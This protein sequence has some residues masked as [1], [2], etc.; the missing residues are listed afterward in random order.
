MTKVQSRLA[1][2]KRVNSAVDD[3]VAYFTAQSLDNRA[4]QLNSLSTGLTAATNTISEASSGITSIQSLLNAA[5]N[6]ANQA[7][8]GTSSSPPTV[9]GTL[10]NLNSNSVIATT[11]GSGNRFKA[12]DTVTVNDGTT[13]ATYTAANNDTVSTFLAAIN[14]TTGL[15]VTASLNASGQIQLA[16]SSAVTVTVGG[17]INGAGGGTLS[18]I[19]GLTAGATAP[20]TSTNT[21]LR[22][23]LAA[24]YD[25]IRSQIDAAAQDANYNGVN[26]LT[27]S[28]LSVNLNETGSSKLAISGGNLASAGLGMSASTNNWQSNSDVNNAVTQINAAMATLQT[29]S[30]VIGA[31]SITLQSRQDF[32]KATISNLQSGS[33]A[34]TADDTNADSALLA[35]L[36]NR[37]QLATAALSIYQQQ[38]ST[39]LTLL[40]RLI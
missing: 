19:L 10:S 3:P 27:G 39:A 24:Q 21:S 30:A 25:S 9:T 17:T 28:T 22:Q 31:Q 29:T 16:A 2:G 34:L 5:L 18:G 23:S 11:P 20:T 37:Q 35:E 12:G 6:I 14:N 33:S 38:Q 13:T 8:A 7:L 32:N 40:N 4:T 36:Q 26:L 15:K 1:T